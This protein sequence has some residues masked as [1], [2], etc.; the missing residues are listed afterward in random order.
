MLDP[1]SCLWWLSWSVVP[2][3]G[4]ATIWGYRQQLL[5][6]EPPAEAQA[7]ALRL[8]ERA[9]AYGDWWTW[10]DDPAYP[11]QI[12]GI[13]AP[14]PI[15]WGRGPRFDTPLIAVV[16]T[17]TPSPIA[18]RAA[19]WSAQ[20]IVAAGYGVVSGGARGIDRLAH[21][22]ASPHTVVV[23][24]SGLRSEAARNNHD[25]AEDG[26]TLLSEYHDDTYVLGRLFARNR[27]LVALSHGVIPIAATAQ[28]GTM[29][30]VQQA[31]SLGR[32]L[33]IWDAAWVGALGT[34]QPAT[35]LRRNTFLPWLQHV[36]AAVTAEE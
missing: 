24:S 30:A 15:L 1:A 19:S 4:A 12:R 23:L 18:A 17:R 10:P 3:V 29:H 35:S 2:R 6:P 28:S 31:H 8:L 34:V 36:A 22:A 14:P 33:G 5:P 32:P 21:Q 11:Q 25:I 20:Q 26:G 7:T 9:Q 16:G 13:T 27:L